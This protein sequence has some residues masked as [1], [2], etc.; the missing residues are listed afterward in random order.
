MEWVILTALVA[1][2]LGILYHVLHALVQQ[3][4]VARHLEV[5]RL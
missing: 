1:V 2:G 3:V 5:A 4:E